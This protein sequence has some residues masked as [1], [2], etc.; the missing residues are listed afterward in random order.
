MELAGLLLWVLGIDLQAQQHYAYDLSGNLAALSA[1]SSG[2]PSIAAQPQPQLW[3][4]NTPLLFSVVGSG[5]NLS[6]Q[7]WSNGVPIFG[8]TGD[9][10]LLPNPGGTN[11]ASY[12][13][14]LSSASG[15]VTSAPAVIWLDS[16]A[17]GLPDW[18]ETKYFGNLNQTASGDFDGDG[19]SNLDEFLEGTNPADPTSFNPRLHTQTLHGRIVPTPA[20]PYYTNGQVISLAAIPDDGYSFVGWSGSVKGTKPA[21]SLVMD[22]HKS[23]VAA[24]AVPLPVALDNSSFVWT[25][26]TNTPWFGQ[27]EVSYDGLSSA[28]SGA[29][30]NSQ[31]A[32]LQTVA[33]I[34][35]PSR[36]SFWWKVSSQPP[37]AVVFSINGTTTATLSGESVPWQFYQTVLQPGS[38][39]LQWTYS[40]DSADNGTGIPFAD[41][42]W[43]D[44]VAL[45][46]TNYLP[47][48]TTQPQSQS[49]VAGMDVTFS[50]SATASLPV[51]YRWQFY[52]TNLPGATGATLTLPSV[53]TG[54]SGTYQVV[55]STA[56]G[57]VLSSLAALSVGQCIAPPA[58][59]VA[60]WRAEGNALDSAG[61]NNGTLVSGATFA[62]GEVGQAFSFSGGNDAIEVADSA[63]LRIAPSITI[64]GWVLVAG[65]PS[66]AQWGQILFR[67]DDREGLD[68]YFL[69]V[70]RNGQ[71]AFSINDSNNASAVLAVPVPTHVFVH[72]AGTLDDGSGLMTLYTNGQAAAELSTS[73]RPLTYL[74]PASNPGLGIGNNQGIP[75][76]SYRMGFNGL[77]DEISLYNR[78]LSSTEIAALY[79]A[80]VAG[81]CTSRPVTRLGGIVASNGSMVISGSGG[82]QTGVYYV[83]ASTNAALPMSNWTRLS[84]NPFNTDGSF[85]VTNALNPITPQ[86][87][88]RIQLP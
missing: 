7:W 50:V 19:V 55:V 35:Q 84:T 18:W 9:S 14:V 25:T 87:F 82:P 79:N 81:K 40:K 28:Q 56:Y 59:L 48:I 57:S 63:S 33:S 15:S 41:A 13:C 88:Y 17:N 8:A 66:A 73:V 72:V 23:V 67:G 20:L 85:S 36:L 52:G 5:A 45:V 58:G 70:T 71:L 38:Y 32:W 3:Q 77:I 69:A 53:Q 37:D 42:A 11:F 74:D 39:T 1:S 4:A 83:L 68:P 61:T 65:F 62:P 21:I 64:E 26:S 30:G 22:S 60:W 24:F 78:A 10:L 47:T 44:Q 27:Q 16:N 75:A 2:R 34:T 80:G 29:V 43:L 46:P 31:Q 12:T 86:E 6:Y 51:T 76:S 54:N 49:V